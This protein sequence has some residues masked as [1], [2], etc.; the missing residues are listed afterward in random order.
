MSVPH[1]LRALTAVAVLAPSL[2][3]ATQALAE[4]PD[5]GV[6]ENVRIVDWQ[7]LEFQLDDR[8]KFRVTDIPDSIRRL[9]GAR[10]RMRGYFHPGSVFS[11]RGIKQFVLLGEIQT[12]AASDKSSWHEIPLHYW[13]T[14]EMAESQSATFTA[15]PIE[16][17]GR[18]AIKIRSFQGKPFAIFQIV[19]DTV[20]RTEPRPGYHPAI[21]SGC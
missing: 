11:Q 13:L 10:V 19:A 21:M 12:K 3:V 17:T 6:D 9:E 4:S 14:V 18:F 16:V 1:I 15:K 5:D 20:V 7:Q 2:V 8:S